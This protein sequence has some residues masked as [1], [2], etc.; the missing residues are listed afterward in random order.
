VA[1]QQAGAD[2]QHSYV[3]AYLA[4]TSIERLVVNGEADQL[5]VGDV[6]HCLTVFPVVVVGFGVEERTGLVDTVDVRARQA[7]GPAL[8]R[9]PRHPMWSLDSA[10]SDSFWARTSRWSSVSLKCQGSAR[11]AG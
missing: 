7:V 6:D 3:G 9:L 10:N 2:V 1:L 11:W 5:A 4:I 8:S